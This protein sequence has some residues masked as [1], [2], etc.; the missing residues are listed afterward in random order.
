MSN[1]VVASRLLDCLRRQSDV[2]GAEIV[3]ELVESARA[4]DR[5][6]RRRAGHRPG[7]RHLRRGGAELVGDVLDRLATSWS[8]VLIE[9]A[10]EARV[11]PSAAAG[12]GVLA[13]Q[14]AAA[15][16]DQAATLIPS[17]S[18]IGSSSRSTSR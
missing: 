9:F 6:H 12:P 18:A 15:Q 16:R 4:D 8:C 17:A 3:E 5:V 1:P 10:R 14:H 11:A 13:R 7:E 2:D